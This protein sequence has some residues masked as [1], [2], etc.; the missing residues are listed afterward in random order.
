MTKKIHIIGGGTYF[1]VR[2]HLS[3]AAR[4][5]GTTARTI[6]HLIDFWPNQLFSD[7][8][9]TPQ[10]HLTSMGSPGSTLVTNADVAKL[11]DD[12]VGLSSTKVIIMSAAMC[13][14]EGSVTAYSETDEWEGDISPSGK[15]QP[16]LSSS[17]PKG[18]Y[19]SMR[20]FSAEKVIKRIR[21]ERKDIFLVAFKTT[22]GATPQEQFDAGLN[23]LKKNSCNLVLA[24]DYHTKLNMVVT[25]EEA[26]HHVTAD[27][28]EALRGLVEMVGQ[29]CGLNYTR[30]TVIKGELIDWESEAIPAVLREVVNHCIE[31]GAYKPFNGKTAGHF[32]VRLSET[33]FIT[34]CRKTN[35]NT[36]LHEK[37]MCKVFTQGDDRVV[38]VGA[39]PSV[40]GQSQRIIFGKYPHLDSIVHFHCPL[41]PEH[42]SIV[43]KRP[44]AA[45]EC[46]SHE[47]GQNA[48]D[49][50]APLPGHAYNRDLML[51]YLEDHG[52]N[53]VF[54]SKAVEAKEV[55]GMIEELFDLDGSTRNVRNVL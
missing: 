53:I 43:S 25:P 27:R 2:P 14:F 44:Q 26:P 5:R 19:Y 18:G 47:C 3:I 1:D 28:L 24:N 33:D 31:R 12:L 32:A 41:R 7:K 4:A 35:Y 16:R 13:D 39:K 42:Q 23:L 46:G 34:S 51:V 9:L 22:A 55:I 21:K 30:S 38:A 36:D 20:L 52:P 8:Y 15:D 6:E 45:F 10:L 37:G 48:A 11:I 49:G 54:N 50:L 40:G 29:R 17:L